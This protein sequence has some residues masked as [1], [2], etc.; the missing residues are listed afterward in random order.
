MMQICIPKF[1]QSYDPFRTTTNLQLKWRELQ[2]MQ[3]P[4]EILVKKK[5]TTKRFWVL[6]WIGWNWLLCRWVPNN[7][8]QF[9]Q[10]SIFQSS[11]TK[12]ER[13]KINN[14]NDVETINGNKMD[15]VTI[16]FSHDLQI[17]KM[18]ARSNVQMV[19]AALIEKVI[20]PS[21]SYKSYFIGRKLISVSKFLPS[22]HF[23]C[24]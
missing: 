1:F 21:T 6:T 13:E 12:R 8:N 4:A 23:W 10:S 11:K 15:K 5:I 18:L 3:R 2:G 20:E 7:S 9:A 22:F 24:K 19:V 16:T 14:K 17:K